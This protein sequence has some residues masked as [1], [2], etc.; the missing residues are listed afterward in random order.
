M[1]RSYLS[2]STLFC[3]EYYK[4]HCCK[5]TDNHVE[6]S[7]F[8]IETEAT[9]FIDGT[10]II[11]NINLLQHLKEIKELSINDIIYYLNLH[12]LNYEVGKPF[13]II[14]LIVQDTTPSVNILF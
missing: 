14:T 7:P 11:G 2:H 13:T 10:I 3:G 4:M 5:I 8:D 9:E 12:S 1:R 6:L